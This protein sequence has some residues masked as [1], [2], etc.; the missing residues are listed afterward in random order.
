LAAAAAFLPTLSAGFVWDDYPTQ[1]TALPAY[2]SFAAGFGAQGAGTRWIYRPIATCLALAAYRANE[3]LFGQSD[4]S[5]P[6][7]RVEPR[8]ARLPHA[9]SLMLHAVNSGLVLLLVRR[10]L[11]WRQGADAGALLGGLLFALHP[12]HAENVAWV[13]AVADSLAA[14]FLLTSLLAAL[15]ALDSGFARWHVLSGS[16]YLLALLSKES[17][18]AGILL[19][20]IWLLMCQGRAGTNVGRRD[21]GPPMISYAAAFATYLT[22]RIAVGG[23]LPGEAAIP[24]SVALSSKLLAAIGFYVRKLFFPWPPTPFVAQFPASGAT[25]ASL[26][27]AFA[28][29]IPSVRAW[30]SGD[31]LYLLC[32]G[33]FAVAVAPFLLTLGESPTRTVA[34]ERYLYIPSIS[35]ALAAGG[36]AASLAGTRYRRTLGGAYCALLLVL[37]V[38][39]WRASAPWSSSLSLWRHVTSQPQTARFPLPWENLGREL[40]RAGEVEPA[41]QAF[42]QAIDPGRSPDPERLGSVL[43]VLCQMETDRGWSLLDETRRLDAA[44]QFSAAQRYCLRAAAADPEETGNLLNAGVAGLGEFTA[45]GSRNDGEAAALLEASCRR[46][47]A[48]ARNRADDA[49]AQRQRERCWQ[50]WREGPPQE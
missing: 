49:W 23:G 12:A 31:R 37:G 15:K 24:I 16:L 47:E 26:I 19:L 9:I 14:F 40:M 30:R 43:G 11:R 34:A 3:A 1:K 44:L 20:P 36:L 21:L 48:A 38:S 7:D 27:A 17:A 42:R 39:C 10:C 46:I 2:P 29:V 4:P 25:A 22:L 33:W 45:R 5:R 50:L 41:R 8:R 18:V 35:L 32:G 13:A 6:E 28:L